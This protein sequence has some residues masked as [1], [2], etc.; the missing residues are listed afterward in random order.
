MS[1]A[2]APSAPCPDGYDVDRHFNPKYDPWDQRLC[3]VPDGDLFE[4]ISSG[5]AE[6]VTDRIASLHRERAS[7]S[8][9]ARELE[10]D[11][12]VTATGLNLL[13]LGGVELTRRRRGGRHPLDARLQG[14]DAQRRP[15]PG[16]HARLHERLLDAE[17]RPHLRIHVPPDQPHGRARLSPVR[18]AGQ[19]PVGA[20]RAGHRPQLR[21]RPALPRRSCPNRARRS[22][23]SCARTT[24]STCVPC[25]T[26]RSSTGRCSSPARR[27]GPARPS[28]LPPRSPERR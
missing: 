1:C 16:L 27:A 7:S 28:R 18:A 19:R 21:L 11:A 4:A 6:V 2:R 13:F 5:R 10:A 24:R 14:D 12:I 26:A 3:L 23:G 17:G 25:A 9:R 8:S 20:E 22:P 15:Q